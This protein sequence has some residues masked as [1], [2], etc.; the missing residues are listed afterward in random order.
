V[1]GITTPGRHP[2][3]GYIVPAGGVDHETIFEAT[4]RAARPMRDVRPENTLS[5]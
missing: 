4:D 5:A 3:T 1:L 2:G